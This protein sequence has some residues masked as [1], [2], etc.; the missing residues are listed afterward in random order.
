[1][2]EKVA[3]I[4]KKD[5]ETEKVIDNILFPYGVMVAHELLE[6]VVFVRFNVRELWR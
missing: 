3:I 2:Q 5:T 4:E 6:F 1:M